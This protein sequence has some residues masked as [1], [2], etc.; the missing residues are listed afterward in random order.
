MNNVVRLVFVYLDY[1]KLWDFNE[2]VVYCFKIIMYFIQVQY[3]YYVIQEILG[4]FDVCKK[5]V[6]WV[7]VGI[8]QVLLEVVVIV[9]KGF[10]GLIVLEVF[11]IFLK[12]LCFSVEFEVNDLQGGFVGS[13]NLNI[14]FKDNDEKIVQ[15][16]II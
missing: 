8:I 16:V 3:F 14:S 2:F 11:N 1:Y 15:N 6:F 10:I 4:Y 12:Y 7:W 9:V 5:D 13:V